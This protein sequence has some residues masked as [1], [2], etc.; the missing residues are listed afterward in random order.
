LALEQ[1]RLQSGEAALRGA[2]IEVA[3]REA[4]IDAGAAKIQK[5]QTV[6]DD[7]MLKAPIRGRVLY[8]LA[9]PGEVLAA[10]GKVLTV[11]ELT[12]VYMTIFLPTSL[13]GRLSIGVEARIILDA[14]PQYVIPATVSS[15]RRA[16]NSL[17]RKSRPRRSARS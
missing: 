4:A 6:I 16:R 5:I 12:D 14:V 7:S 15:L 13:A 10:G 8:R 17:P 9:E 3:Q 1:A 2:R 11:I